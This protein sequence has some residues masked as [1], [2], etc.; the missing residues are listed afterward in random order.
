MIV[1]VGSKSYQKYL[2]CLFL[3]LASTFSCNA[4]PIAVEEMAARSTHAQL[5]L[6]L[7]IVSAL[8]AEYVAVA[9]ALGLFRKWSARN[10]LLLAT[11]Q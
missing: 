8:A 2:F 4:N 1:S 11:I 7:S 9:W 5:V 3:L 6:V 10:M